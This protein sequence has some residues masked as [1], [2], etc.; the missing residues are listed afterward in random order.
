MKKVFFFFS[1]QFWR[2]VVSLCCSEMAATATE[3]HDLG[4]SGSLRGKRTVYI[5]PYHILR[6]NPGHLFLFVLPVVPSGLHQR[7]P[8][9]PASRALH[10]FLPLRMASGH[11]ARGDL[12]Q[13]PPTSKSFL[14]SSLGLGLTRWRPPVKPVN[15][16]S[17][18]VVEGWISVSDSARHS[19][20]PLSKLVRTW[21]PPRQSLLSTNWSNPPLV[22][23][24]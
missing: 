13:L 4:P 22:L 14:C 5:Y 15:C 16:S 8:S 6:W 12:P 11:F 10:L 20:A 21:G 24:I 17:Q 9:V 1:W 7:F 2:A 19:P 18:H 3:E 23:F